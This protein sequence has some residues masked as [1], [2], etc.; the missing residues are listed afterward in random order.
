MNKGEYIGHTPGLKRRLMMWT[1][2]PFFMAKL[3]LHSSISS[4][5]MRSP[6]VP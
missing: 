6:W 2:V 5:L 4:T 3:V 1:S